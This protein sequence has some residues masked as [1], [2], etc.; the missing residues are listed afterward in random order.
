MSHIKLQAQP[1]RVRCSDACDPPPFRFDAL[2]ES[3]TDKGVATHVARVVAVPTRALVL[4]L[5]LAGRA[6]DAVFFL[7]LITVV[8][9]IHLVLWSYAFEVGPAAACFGLPCPAWLASRVLAACGVLMVSS[10]AISRV[11]RRLGHRATSAVLLMLVTFN[12]AAML[13]LGIDALMS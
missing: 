1:R 4:L 3:G 2:R 5:G 12:L 8:C 13:V 10:F 11:L 7:V 6:I 9:A